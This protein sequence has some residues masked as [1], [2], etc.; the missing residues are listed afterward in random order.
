M[1]RTV[2]AHAVRRK[3]L[4]DVAEGLFHTQ[5]YATTTVEDI[6]RETGVAK[7]TFYHYFRSKEEVLA[8]LATRM[9]D[10]MAKELRKIAAETSVPPISRLQRMFWVAQRIGDHE[11]SV[12]NDLHRSENRELHD[13]NNVEI[14]RVLGPIVAEVIEQ[15]K[16]DG[17]FDV[18]DPVSTVQF[19]MAGSLFLFGEGVFDWTAEERAARVR[20]MK[21]LIGRTLRIDPF[22]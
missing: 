9:V 21:T 12:V 2:K 13:R 6:V 22:K 15:G 4:L 3:E 20:A 5:G 7:G 10:T 8:A 1:A 19:L 11:R 17:T 16:A 18:D 14:V